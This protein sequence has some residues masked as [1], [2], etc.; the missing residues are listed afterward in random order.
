MITEIN[1]LYWNNG[2]YLIESHKKVMEYLDIPVNYHNIDGANPGLWMNYVLENS[3][4]DI[5]G[6]LDNERKL[7]RFYEKRKTK[8]KNNNQ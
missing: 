1:T 7:L 2:S 6:F 4:S 8:N 3:K 5:I